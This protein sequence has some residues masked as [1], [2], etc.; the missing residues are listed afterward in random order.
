MDRF[1]DETS[2]LDR[3]TICSNFRLVN[4]VLKLHVVAECLFQVCEGCNAIWIMYHLVVPV[5]I[6]QKIGKVIGLILCVLLYDTK[7]TGC[8][9]RP[10]I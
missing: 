7:S 2:R 5:T 1:H 6:G 4:L 8:D 9:L 10:K 3:M